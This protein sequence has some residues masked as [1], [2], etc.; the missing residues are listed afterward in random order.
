MNDYSF[1]GFL[2]WALWG[3]QVFFLK[4]GRTAIPVR[5]REIIPFSEGNSL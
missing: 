3:C 5:E 2:T 1:N 4:A